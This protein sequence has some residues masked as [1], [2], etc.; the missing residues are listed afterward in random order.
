MENPR[1]ITAAAT[2]VLAYMQEEAAAL[3][4]GAPPEPPGLRTAPRPNLWGMSGRQEIMQ[5]GTLMQL[6]ALQR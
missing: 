3:Q 2:A 4:A 5:M 6:R 1:K